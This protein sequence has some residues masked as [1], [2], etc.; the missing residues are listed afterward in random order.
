MYRRAITCPGGGD[1]TSCPGWGAPPPPGTVPPH[2]KGPGT[3]HWDTPWKG[4][5]TMGCRWRTP[6]GCGLT[7]KL[8]TLSSPSF[9]CCGLQN[10]FTVG[11]ASGI[12]PRVWTDTQT[13][14]ITF[15]ILRM[16]AAKIGSQWDAL[17]VYPLMM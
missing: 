3:S 6:R 12:L 5:G 17:L 1:T 7:H 11:R 9:G 8:K 16:W 13:E 4:H 14:N 15:T 10:W 2:Q